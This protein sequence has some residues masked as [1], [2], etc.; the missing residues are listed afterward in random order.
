MH[1]RYALFSISIG[2]TGRT[3]N[4]TA[5][6][7]IVSMANTSSAS[8]TMT[9]VAATKNVM[10]GRVPP[11][12]K[13]RTSS[14]IASTESTPST[15]TKSAVPTHATKRIKNCAQTTTSTGKKVTTT[16]FATQVVTM[17][18]MGARIPPC[19]A[20]A[21][22]ARAARAKPRRIFT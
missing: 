2:A 17:S 16:I 15:H 21:R 13:T 3:I 6:T 1:V 10:T 4:A 19:P 11:S 8:S 20:M 22:R 18:C 12:A 7:I 9:V 5:A 14:P